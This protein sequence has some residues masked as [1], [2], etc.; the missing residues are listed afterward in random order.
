[1]TVL[2]ATRTLELA[3][4]TAGNAPATSEYVG[5]KGMSSDGSKIIFE[6]A[7]NMVPADN[8]GQTDV[9]ERSAGVTTLLS[10]SEAPGEPSHFPVYFAGMTPDGSHVYM[11]TLQRL[12]QGDND[13]DADVYDRSA[14]TTTLVSAAGSGA[15]PNPADAVFWGVSSDG[16]TVVFSTTQRLTSAD[17]NSVEDYFTRV[18]TTTTLVSHADA[19]QPARADDFLTFG[20]ISASGNHIVFSTND[21]LKASD[22]DIY[23]DVYDY[24]NGALEL[25]SAPGSGAS[26]T[27]DPAYYDGMSSD[28]SKV[29]FES[30]QSLLTADGDGNNDVYR[31]TSGTTAPALMTMPGTGADPAAD[32]T[33]RGNTSD[34]GTLFFMTTQQMGTTTNDTD[35]NVDVYSGT[36]NTA[37]TLVSAPDVNAP[38]ATSQDVTYDGAST[39]G[40][41]VFWSTDQP[42]TSD[43]TDTAADIYMTNAGTTTLVSVGSSGN[44]THGVAFAGN[45]PDG[46]RIAF[47]TDEQLTNADSDTDGDIYVRG[48][49]SGTPQTTLASGPGSGASGDSAGV[50]FHAMSTDANHVAFTTPEHLVAGDT[51][52]L[53]DIYDHGAGFTTLVSA[54]E[55]G[56]PNTAFDATF[57]ALS[58]DGNSTLFSTTENLVAGDTDGVPDLYKRSNGVTTLVV[59]ANGPPAASSINYDAAS[60]NFG[61]IIF[62]T[63]MSLTGDDTDGGVYDL[64]SASGGQMTLLTPGTAQAVDFAGAS[65]DA[66]RVVFSTSENLPGDNDGEQDLYSR[67]GGTT[68]L[69]TPGTTQ[70]VDY[71]LMSKDATK[72]FFSSIEDLAGAAA[73]GG[74]ADVFMASA[75]TISLV[76]AVGSGVNSEPNVGAYLGGVSDDGSKAV[77]DATGFTTTDTGPD[78]DL[79]LHTSGGTTLM[80]A[81]SA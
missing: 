7:Q 52:S 18:G 55:A 24:S 42:M 61:T 54:P 59:P 17:D 32:A 77:F 11:S 73:D 27:D 33:Y 44:G 53:D 12:G 10:V 79:Y 13:T 71:D 23:E 15:D 64:Y 22:T 48:P 20:G 65:A 76:S 47:V 56:T 40:S 50:M 39:N 4:V 2:G 46:D 43:D 72:V 75:G 63:A 9:Y 1:M 3:S 29:F 31:H 68:T 69:L 35:S 38:A 5:F 58:S 62:G 37:A 14:G 49:F 45:T 78:G 19:G 30:Y 81:G 67:I 21:Q 16:S 66:S 51:D 80:S 36:P 28:G 25:I 60:P 74:N 57:A 41:R 6:T 26:A 34:G 8:D 70:P